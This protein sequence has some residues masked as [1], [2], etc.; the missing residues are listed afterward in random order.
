MREKDVMKIQNIREEMKGLQQ[1][2]SSVRL[3]EAEECRGETARRALEEKGNSTGLEFLEAEAYYVMA[4]Y[5]EIEGKQYVME[6]VSRLEVNFSEALGEYEKLTGRMIEYDRRVFVD[7]LTGAYNRRYYEE[8]VKQ[9]H[10]VCGV[11]MI[12]MDDFKLCNDTFGHDSGDRALA[13]VAQEILKCIRESDRLIRYG[14]D[15]FLLLLSDV[16]EEGFLKTLRRIKDRVH[17]AVVPGY[18]KIQLTV[19]IGGAISDGNTPIKSVISQADR[20]M[21]VAKRKKNE[22]VTKITAFLDEGEEKQ[23]ILIVDDSS[24]NRDLLAEVLRE[25]YEVLEAENGEQ[26]MALLQRENEEI[27]LVLL[28]VVMPGMDGFAVLEEMEKRHWL[29]TIPVIMITSENTVSAVR[30]AYNAG[31]TD[32]ISRPFD[33]QVVYRRVSNAVKLYARQRKLMEIVRK[34][35]VEQEKRRRLT[36]EI[37][38]RVIGTRNGENAVHDSHV[39][40]IT[41]LLLEK[42]T[43]K[44]DRYDLSWTERQAMTAAASFHD[45]GKIGIEEKLLHKENPTEKEKERLR[46]HTVIGDEILSSLR[47][48]Q[49]EDLVRYAR[50]ISRWHHERYDGSGYPDGLKGEEIP[51]AAQVVGLADTYEE[52]MEERRG[53]SPEEAIRVLQ[54]EYRDAFQPLL[55]ECMWE[56]KDKIQEVQD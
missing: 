54:E 12:D 40:T 49:R 19:S 13:T 36:V 17:K 34:Q 23:K 42:I 22:V 51:I 43:E 52:I 26:C 45:I 6:L 4:R 53:G 20:F 44:T 24:L 32:Y 31:I 46:E 55:L 9:S 25:E 21:Y 39:G 47:E 14:G 48:Y 33:M 18:E 3:L 28:D 5:L 50:Q 2:F 11:A 10:A 8:K 29:D 1:I 41:R 37:L 30:R 56:L 16:D 27:S 38:S 7:S 35:G 15:E